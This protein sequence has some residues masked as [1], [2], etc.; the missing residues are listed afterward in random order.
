[1]KLYKLLDVL[2]SYQH[3]EIIQEEDNGL[4]LPVFNGLMCDFYVFPSSRR[5]YVSWYNFSVDTVDTYFDDDLEKTIITIT[6]VRD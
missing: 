1:M 4:L 2:L 6:I 5:K 3:I